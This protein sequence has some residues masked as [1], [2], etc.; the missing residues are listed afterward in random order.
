[1]RR[2]D[3]DITAFSRRIAGQE[4]APE[5]DLLVTTNDSL[6]VHLLTPL[7]AKFQFAYAGMR[8]EIFVANQALN[9][10]KRDADVAIRASDKPPENLVGRRVAKIARAPSG[11]PSD[12]TH[13]RGIDPAKLAERRW[14]SL[15]DNLLSLKAARHVRQHVPMERNI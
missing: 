13:S 10:S 9:L 4:I 14:V 1:A 8:L 2:F 12:I 3:T 15:C 7:L 6:L 5:G 11:R